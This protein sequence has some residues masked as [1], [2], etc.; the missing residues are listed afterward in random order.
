M[1]STGANSLTAQATDVAGNTG[2]SA[3]FVATLDTTPPALAVTGIAPDTGVSA[4]DGLTDVA[5]VAVSGTIDAADAGLAITVYDG[6]RL[7]GTT[8]AD[9]G[10]NWSLAGVMLSSG[11]NS[12]TAQAT[13]AAGNTG[14]SA[15]F[16]ATL[17]QTPPTLTVT[18][19][20]PDSGTSATD[21]LTDVATVAVS[22]TIDAADAGLTVA[23]YDGATLVGTTTADAGGNWS[24]AGVMLS[25]GANSLT[26]QATDAAGNTGTSAAFVAT[27]D[28]TPPALAVTGISPDTGTSASDGLTNVATVTVRGTIDA[29]DAGLAIT[30]YDGA[31]LVGTTTANAGGNWSLAGVTLAAGANS[32]TAQATDAAGNTGTSA[33]FVA[34]LDTTPPALTVTGISPD[35]GVSATDGLTNVAIV[36]VSGTIDAADAGLSISVYDGATLIGTTTADTGG[37]WSLAGVTLAAGVNSLTA[38]ATDAAGN[39]GT[40]AAFVATLDTTPPTLAVTGISPDT[41]TSA[42]DGLTNVAT[43]TVSGTIDAADAGLAITV[44]DGT[45][46]VGTTTADTGG[47]WSSL[48]ASRWRRARTA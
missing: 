35:T 10:G 3:A 44:Y 25:S 41:G 29:A 45:T 32:L 9:A 20:A 4:S 18:A 33:A 43:V 19:I 40:S 37:N 30:V 42:S 31:T 46:L 17:D 27:L 47:N 39:I 26:A 15:A 16:V 8:T 6:T 21:G 5:T 28:T 12:L 14:T 24:L 22:G 2:T 11:A 38:Q 1:L 13:D 7:V 34:T 48:P 36:A 23:V